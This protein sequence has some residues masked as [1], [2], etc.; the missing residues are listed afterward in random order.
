M[1]RITLLFISSLLFAA[2]RG[3]NAS[4]SNTPAQSDQTTQ[5][6]GD[7][8][9]PDFN[10]FY[11]KFHADSLYQVAHISW[12]LQGLTTVQLDSTRQ[13]KQAIYWEKAN[14]RMH[15]PVNFSSGEFQ[16]KLQVLG[17]ELV[18][19]HISYAAANFG[20]ERR[21]V[22][23]NQGEWELIYYADMQETGQ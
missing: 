8:L 6:Q 23:S 2:C 13:E 16:R 17:D 15:R 10:E 5:V 18:V 22:R 4:S 20:L 7:Q 9:P 12:P 21:F 19:E 3:R 1:S 11:E 14:W